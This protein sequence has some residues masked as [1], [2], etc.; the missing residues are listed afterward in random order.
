MQFKTQQNL[1]LA[2]P[3]MNTFLLLHSFSMSGVVVSCY[4]YL[5]KRYD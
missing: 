2:L 4:D 5:K 1:P 3:G